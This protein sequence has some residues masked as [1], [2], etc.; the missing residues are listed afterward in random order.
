MQYHRAA[1]ERGDSEH[2]SEMFYR[3][4]QNASLQKRAETMIAA[5]ASQE[6]LFEESLRTPQ[7]PKYHGEGPFMHDHL[8]LMLLCLYAILD[9]EMHFLD[10]EELRE[11]KGYE[12]D[13]EEVE[14][15]IRENASFFEVFV[16]LHDIGKW[17]SLF[18]KASPDSRG[19]SAGFDMP[20]SLRFKE[21]GV[22]ELNRLRDLYA[23]LF[24][25][26]GKKHPELSVED[27]QLLFAKE[28]G[29]TC[30]Y[31]GH[32]RVIHAPVYRKLLARFAQTHRL[33]ERSFVLLED[34]IAF[35]LQP[36]ADF[37]KGMDAKRI[38]K[39]Y[40]YAAKKGHDGEDFLRRMQA[41]VFLDGVCGSVRKIQGK[42]QNDIS[43]FTNFLRSEHDYAPW[44]REEKV[45][46]R[47]S[48]E[49]QMNN[50]L[51]REVGLDGIALMELLEMK[52]GPSFGKVLH[53]VH[54]AIL[55][56]GEM[57]VFAKRIM[58]E[59]EVRKGKFFEKKFSKGL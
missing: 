35:H 13:I 36:I 34:V 9:G 44:V 4:R 37:K 53:Q 20:H 52:P 14:E 10:I 7:S 3:I 12:G 6:P 32:D 26:F 58:E 8:R 50:V 29:I 30:H 25:T 59:L 23:S 51:F 31:P 15:V 28:Y 11:L 45:A 22:A 2:L 16:L 42:R 18:F 57:P 40:Q 41:A 56:K 5:A 46:K 21:E 49:R 1:H 17:S 39:Y 54:E 48:K 38:K 27:L 19:A 43:L 55:G 24:E 33:S 47:E